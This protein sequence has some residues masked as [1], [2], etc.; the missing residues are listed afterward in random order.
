MK[1]SRSDFAPSCAL[2]FLI[3][4]LLLGINEK[5]SSQ[6]TADGVTRTPVAGIRSL[7]VHDEVLVALRTRIAELSETL[8]H[9]DAEFT[10][11]C[12]EALAGAWSRAQKQLDADPLEFSVVL[13]AV[14]KETVT[15][16]GDSAPDIDYISAD[17]D[18]L[19]AERELVLAETVRIGEDTGDIT[20]QRF[21][22][23]RLDLEIDP[24]AREKSLVVILKESASNEDGTVDTS[25]ETGRPTDALIAEMET[26]ISIDLTFTAYGFPEDFDATVG[27]TETVSWDV[28]HANA[29]VME[30]SER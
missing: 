14:R 26:D 1:Y 23:C 13:S 16:S 5:V 20:A 19:D 21:V 18:V 10:S 28:S 27:G 29:L 3:A 7:E 17:A 9:E 11:A 6:E 8:D 22:T 2:L 4:S 25:G 12:R 30:L 15:G 24:A